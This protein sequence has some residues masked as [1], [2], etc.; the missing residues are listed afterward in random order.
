MQNGGCAQPRGDTS[1][2]DGPFKGAQ[3]RYLAANVVDRHGKP[4]LPAYAIKRFEGAGGRRLSVAF[5]GEVLRETVSMVS[6]AGV[7]GL[8]SPTRRTPPMRWY[9]SCANR[10]FRPSCC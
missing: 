7:A 9:R 10:V 5:I 4:L 3:F 2:V 8:R 1:C 6:P